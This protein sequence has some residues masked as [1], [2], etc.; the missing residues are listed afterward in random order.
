LPF[1]GGKN[2]ILH[3]CLQSYQKHS[4]PIDKSVAEQI[5]SL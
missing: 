4:K 2:I 1:Y 3:L 5:F